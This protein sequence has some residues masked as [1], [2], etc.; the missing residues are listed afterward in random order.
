MSK[1]AGVLLKPHIPV[2]VIALL[3]SLSGLEPQVLNY[4]SLHAAS[5]QETLEKVLSL[6]RLQITVLMT[7]VILD[8]CSLLIL[9]IPEYF[10]SL[11]AFGTQ[12][13]LFGWNIICTTKTFCQPSHSEY[14][15]NV[16]VDS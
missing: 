10:V 2:L 7:L 8:L 6:H 4:L 15:R 3:E 16:L 5:N 13:F 11:L 1:N 14:Q 12:R 9:L